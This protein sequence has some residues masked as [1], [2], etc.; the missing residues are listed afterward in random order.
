M[1]RDLLDWTNV[2]AV[3]NFLRR[4][5][6]KTLRIRLGESTN[7]VRDLNLRDEAMRIILWSTDLGF[8]GIFYETVLEK[9]DDGP[10]TRT[11]DLFLRKGRHSLPEVLLRIRSKFEN[12]VRQINTNPVPAY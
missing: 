5:D 11:Y 1:V 2:G 7:W 10:E 9:P 12:R 3:I 4:Y 6:V 8:N